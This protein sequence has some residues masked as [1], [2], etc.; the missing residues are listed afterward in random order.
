MKVLFL[1]PS[2][3]VSG[4]SVLFE[5]A[6]RL[7]TRNHE[8]RITSLDEVTKIEFFPLSVIPQ[9]LNE[10]RTFIKEADAIIGYYPVCAYYV[11][12]L[13]TQAKKFCFFI[14][15]QRAFYNREVFKVNYPHLDKDRVEIEYRNQQNYLEKS[16]TLPITYL[17]TSKNTS[18][19]L[20]GQYRRKTVIIP[21]GIN[22]HLYFPEATFMK[23]D[24]IR[25]LVEGNLM[26][27]KRVNE[28]NKALSLLCDYELWT[29]SDTPTTIKSDKHWQNLNVE[30]TRKV[31]S[32]CDILIR[33]YAEDGVAELQAQAMA[34]GCAVITSETNGAKMFCEDSQNCLTFGDEGEIG[35][36]IKKLMANKKLRNTL[37]ANGLETAKKLDWEISAGILEKAIGGK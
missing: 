31:L 14:D 33:A 23:T 3:T 34:C 36:K 5:L 19:F 4:G 6:N 1:L 20:E 37:I 32:S 8:V 22:P 27:W 10:L 9:Q 21:I 30:Q 15:D 24:K 7:F 28:V 18:E 29:M 12:D 11:N 2:L 35:S 26:P 25:I 16:Y 13:V 17:A